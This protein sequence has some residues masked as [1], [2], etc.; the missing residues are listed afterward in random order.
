MG[1]RMAC[2]QCHDHPFD[3]W[4]QTDFHGL[5][6]FFGQTKIREKAPKQG[7]GMFGDA[8]V[9]DSPKGE[10]HMPA[11]GD[12]ANKKGKNGGEVVKPVF[13]WDPAVTL[14]GSKSR[15]EVLA[16]A[17]ISS[18][19]FAQ[20]QVNRLWSQLM[21]RGIV[22]PA[23]DFREKNPPSHP[24]LLDFLAEQLVSAKYDTKHVLRLILNSAAYQRSSAPTDANR[25]DTTLFSHQRIRRMTAEELFDSILVASG[26]EKGL[27]EVPGSLAENNKTGQKGGA[28]MGRKKLAAVD[29]AA[30]LP[31]PA[32]TGTFMNVFNQPPR[33]ILTTKR[34]ESGAVTQ[35]LEMLNGKA[36]NDA[37]A[38]SPLIDHLLASKSDVRNAVTELYLATLTRPPTSHEIETAAKGSDGTRD[39]LV[40]LQW[41][42]MKAREFT[43]VK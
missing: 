36:V 10:Y 31:T 6:A 14:T 15:R 16:D 43:F 5:M 2:A 34:D 42:L 30:D 29:W 28:G 13:P 8:S 11:D 38:R 27:E 35:A 7:K 23:D 17:V 40:D 24:E 19:R 26:H 20:V 3:K 18:P 4:T 22:E 25:S 33:D 37:L 39:W 9:A 12:S 1:S 21:G 32:K 41:A